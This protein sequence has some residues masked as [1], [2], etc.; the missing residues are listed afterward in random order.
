MA[1]SL[2]SAYQLSCSWQ[3]RVDTA[4]VTLNYSTP[5]ENLVDPALGAGAVGDLN[6]PHP[7]P[8]E[9]RDF[10]L[11]DQR[12][13]REIAKRIFRVVS[14]DRRRMFS[15]ALADPVT[16]PGAPIFPSVPTD[17]GHYPGSY[18]AH[19]LQGLRVSPPRYVLELQEGRTAPPDVASRVAGVILVQLT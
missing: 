5:L 3:S 1:I 12:G 11:H 18:F 19:F 4:T 2:V 9:L 10:L 17:T 6:L 7:G 16:I 8:G 13:P 15:A 14:A